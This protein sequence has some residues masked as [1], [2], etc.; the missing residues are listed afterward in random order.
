MAVKMSQLAALDELIFYVNGRKIVE[1]NADP[2]VMLLS[3]LRKKLYLTGTKY[4]C[5][6]GGCGACTVMVSTI[7]PV[8]RKIMHYPATACLLPICSLHGMAVTT[9]EGIGNSATRLHPVQERIAKAHGS[10]CGFCTPGMVMSMYSLLRN[11][12]EPT[13]EQISNALSG[14]LCRCTGYRPI[15]DGCRTFAKDCCMNRR[16]GE[17]MLPETQITPTLFNKEEFVPLDQTQELIFPPEL[18]LLLDKQM[19]RMAAFQGERIN[20]YSPATLSE[21][22]D[23]KTKYPKAPLVVGNT[24]V[25][26]D[27]KFNGVFHP[28]I[29]SPVRIKDLF[30]IN[31][32]KKGITIGAACSLAQVKNILNESVSKEP[33]YQT[34]TYRALIKQLNTLAGEQIRNMASIGGH[35]MSKQTICDLNPVLAAAKAILNVT[36]KGGTRQIPLNEDFFSGDGSSSLK[37]NEILLSVLIPRTQKAEFVSAFKQAQR[38][39]NAYAIVNAGMRVLLN[40]NTHA[41]K[42]M[43]IFYGGMGP[44][45]VS[46]KKTSQALVGRNWDEEMLTEASKMITDEISLPSSATGGKVDYRKALRISFVLKFY[47]EVID[48]LPNPV[49]SSLSATNDKMA[50][51]NKLKS[52]TSLSAPEYLSAIRNFETKAPKTL[53]TFQEVDPNQPPQDPVG[54]PIVHQSAIKQATG[55][56]VFV[57][58]MP[59]VAKELFIAFVTSERAHAKI[60]SIDASEAQTVPGFVDLISAEDVPGSNE[61]DGQGN[62]FSGDVVNCVGQV[63]C[64]VVANTPEHARRAAAKVKISYENLEPVILTMED[65]IKYKSFYEPIKKVIHGN[66]EEAFKTADQIFEGEMHVGGQEQFYMETNSMLIVPRGEDELDMYI[67]TQDPTTAQL[68][69]AKTLGVPSNRIVSHVK[70][71]GGAF[72]GKIT[73]PAIFACASA[74]AAHKTKCPIRC[75]LE[76]GEDMLITAGRHPVFAKYKVG[77][78]NDGRIVAAE[79][80]FYS[81][82][83]CTPDESILI[84]V[85]ILLKMDNAYHFPNLTCIGTACKTNLPSNTAF[86]GFGFP[87]AGMITEAI[88]DAIA[89]KCGLPPDQVREQNLYKGISRTHYNQEFDSTN[90]M[91]CWKECLQKSDYYKRRAEIQEFNKQNYWKKKGI[92]IIPLKF[93]VG[94][95]EKVYHQA[96]ALVHIYR[97]GKVLIAHGGVELGQG[98][99]TKTMQIASRELKIPMSYIFINENSTATIPNSIPSAGSIGTDVYGLAVKRACETLYQ[100]LEPFI[101]QNPNGKWE[102]WVLGAFS[103]R[104]SLSATGF[105]K[106]YDTYIDWEKSEGH[107][108]PYYIFGTGCS[109]IELDCLTGGHK[110]LRTDIVVDVGTSINPGIDIGQLEGA[111]TQGLGYYTIEELEYSPQGVLYSRGPD[112]YKIPAVC[113][114]P[115]ELNVSFLASSK[116]P[117]TIYSSRGLGETAVFLGCTVYFAIKDAIN[118]ARAER[119]LPKE[120][121]FNSPVGPEKIRMACTDHLTNM[122]KKEKPG[123]YVPWSVDVSK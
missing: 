52:P 36:S 105:Y 3:Y 106:G 15:L 12:P 111:F 104:I 14:N 72:G 83:G 77:F 59:P 39:E 44:T 101:N 121:P 95:I 29:I 47:V 41:I 117:H 37:S 9:T 49:E 76:R 119:G 58:D 122:I 60:L 42:E 53:Q 22:L 31:T 96:S 92:A 93:T 84:I 63:I 38:L 89:S 45:T 57:D 33:E 10:Q 67:S 4:G 23:L 112:T 28:V 74:V 54:R 115:T 6:G 5:G 118:A 19:K 102:E 13:M 81:N 123:S 120:Y 108:A 94:F 48:E 110:N 103:E 61:L 8:S 27:M 55:E 34:K 66:T 11:H 107:P 46:A 75:V 80:N 97:D 16:D 7:H 86:R 73:K 35:I 68:A 90:L 65:A 79:V 56:A 26:P 2:E 25:G 114:V 87:Q 1:K 43:N 69:V 82:A 70:R 98:L 109:E 32:D 21:L 88:L 91:R 20:W 99:Y 24:A 71:V 51:S 85:F 100:R 113:D 18:M 64:A 17:N 30:V 62:V 40:E 116:N 78:M 50:V